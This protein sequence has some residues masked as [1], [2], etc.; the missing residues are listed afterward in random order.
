MSNL[1]ALKARVE[2]AEKGLSSAHATRDRESEALMEM[3]RQIRERFQEQDKE[4]AEYRA[5]VEALEANRE[6]MMKMVEGLLQT[7][8]GS[9]EQTAVGTVPKITGMAEAMLEGQPADDETAETAEAG[10]HDALEE[11]ELTEELS[12]DIPDF[13]ESEDDDPERA[14]PD[15]KDL[16]SRVTESV[17]D[18]G[19]LSDAD[20]RD[21]FEILKDEISGLRDR[22]R[23]A[24]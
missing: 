16:I 22:M 4:L 23:S 10:P 15:I 21:E 17:P 20:D 2:R 6:Q 11:V 5:R 8:E 19:P 3:W 1:D 24:S 14:D 18:E 7:I 9:V 12:D 13:Q